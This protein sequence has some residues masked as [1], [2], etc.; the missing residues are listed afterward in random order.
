MDDA[1]TSALQL[2]MTLL[3]A[4]HAAGSPFGIASE[5]TERAG[6]GLTLIGATGTMLHIGTSDFEQKLARAVHVG[7]ELDRSG[8]QAQSLY[9]DDERR[10]ERIAV[11]LRSQSSESGG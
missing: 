11:R 5:V 9:L 6:V 1:G 2:A 10:P 7:T 4:H 8:R 3:A